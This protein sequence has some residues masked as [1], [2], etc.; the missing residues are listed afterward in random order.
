M[1][2]ITQKTYP[3]HVDLIPRTD[4][5]SGRYALRFARDERD[6][7]K[8]MRLRFEVFNLEMGEGLES[9]YATCRDRDEFDASCHHLMVTDR[10]NGEVVGTYRMQTSEMAR[11]ALGFYSDAEFALDPLALLLTDAIELG[12]ACVAKNHRNHR[13]LFLLWR[14]LADY[15]SHNAKRIFFGCCSLTSQ[16]PVEAADVSRY[17]AEHG[18][19]HPRYEALP[20]AA[21]AC[22]AVAPSGAA[23][24][25]PKLMQIY[26]DYGAQIASRPALDTRFKTIDFLALFDVSRIDARI[27]RLFFD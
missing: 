14:G 10:R 7:D 8:I 5:R 24:K 25:L 23:V 6:L 1:T 21:Y 26:L 12:R 3:K 2:V 4:E 27:R 15:V 13:V 20:R 9:S 18:H 22:P 16:D 11:S 17:V 19:R